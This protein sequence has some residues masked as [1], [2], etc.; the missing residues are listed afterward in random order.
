[1]A[2]GGNNILNKPAMDQIAHLVLDVATIKT[3]MAEMNRRIDEEPIRCPMREVVPT[4]EALRAM[5]DDIRSAQRARE[6]QV[7]DELKKIDG[8]IGGLKEDMA[9]Y[10]SNLKWVGT[11][12]AA[13]N[14][15]LLGAVE[16]FKTL[17]SGGP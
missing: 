17:L 4:L 6:K 7:D 10:K 15:L 12:L 16:L 3:T 11:G 14:G 9:G 13:L 8:D 2:N 1:M 5:C